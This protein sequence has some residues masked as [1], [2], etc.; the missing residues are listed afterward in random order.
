[1]IVIWQAECL[2]TVSNSIAVLSTTVYVV[3]QRCHCLSVLSTSV[4]HKFTRYTA[5]TRACSYL[6]YIRTSIGLNVQQ[7]CTEVTPW[8]D[9]KVPR[10]RYHMCSFIKNASVLMS[11]KLS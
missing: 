10:Q 2:V 3:K 6:W 4:L 9:I 8:L 1:M 11:S 5:S 7:L